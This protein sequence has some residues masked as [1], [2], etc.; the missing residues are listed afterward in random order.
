[1]PGIIEIATG[2][3]GV[4]ALFT[5]RIGGVST[6]SYASLNLGSTTGDDPDAV[7]ANRM[8]LAQAVGA[9]AARVVTMRQVHGATVTHAGPGGGGGAFTGDLDGCG[10]SDAC[11]T[12]HAG[13]ALLAMGADCPIIVAWRTDG[14]A[15]AAIHAGWRGLVAG[16]VQAGIAEL[17]AGPGQVA[18]AV[19]PHVGPCCYPV[20]DVLRHEMAGLFGADVVR[21]QA[22]DLGLCATRALV[23]AGVPEHRCSSIG[24]CTSCDGR[25]F[26]S[27]RR[28]GQA[29]GR[30]AALVMMEDG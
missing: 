14:A 2:V 20:D 12:G 11:V 3:A 13:V 1:M 19:G 29:T 17:D 4:R 9:D 18:A 8:A 10:D 25:R 27:Y 23:A 5:T 28:D 24:A 16:V 6:G 7:R 15:V 22:V 30:Q 21:G 26:F